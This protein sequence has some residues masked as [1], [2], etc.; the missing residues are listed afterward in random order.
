MKIIRTILCLM[1]VMCFGMGTCLAE[2]TAWKNILLLGGDARSKTAYGR[3]DTMIVVSVNRDEGL[4]KMTSIMRDTYVQYE[5]REA[6]RINSANVYGGPEL[7]M[8]VVNENFGLD[9]A[10]YV[11]VNMYDLV[12]IIDLVGGVDLQITESE[13]YY[14]N[15]GVTDYLKNISSY[16]GATSLDHSGEVHLNGLLAVAYCRNRSTDND[17]H[18]VMRQQKVLLAL[19]DQMQNLDIDVLMSL[20][21][22]I[23]EQVDTNMENE[24]I[25][26]LAYAVMTAELEEVESFRVPADGTFE[27]GMFK[28]MWLIRPDFEENQK[29]LREFIYGE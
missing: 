12:K 7:A 23:L 13:R 17:Y 8:K 29:L 10:D 5:G 25:E 26:D 20:A 11:I 15:Q 16:Q 18:R 1:L 19:A 2:E 28:G 21:D 3:T 24:T 9:I 22:E 27:S 14:I 6:H 4:L